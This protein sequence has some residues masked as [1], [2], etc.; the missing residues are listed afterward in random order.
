MTDSIADMGTALGPDVLAASLA[1]FDT[2]Q[3]AHAAEMPASKV[4]LA[5]GPHERHRLDI[6]GAASGNVAKPIVLFVHGG[7]FIMGDKGGDADQWANAH[8]GRWAARM[9]W[10]GAVMNYRLAPDNIW[11]SGAQDVGMVVRWLRAN[12]AEFGGDTARIF[13]IGTSAGAVHISGFLKL[14]TDETIDPADLVRG[15]VLLSG[16]YGYTPI[17]AKDARYYGDAALYDARMPRDAVAMTQLPLFIATAQFDPPRF[18]AEF[19]ALMSARLAQHGAMPCGYI[20]QGQNH[21]SLSLHLG[22]QDRRL[23][24]EIAAFMQRL[25]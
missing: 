19:L 21:Y 5:Y 20:A 24:D 1:L 23:S 25:S 10:L 4:D 8:V 17:D 18:Q 16:L 22:T 14:C 9:G 6:Y 3:S 7:G 2:E 12:A 13:L 11:P 15:A